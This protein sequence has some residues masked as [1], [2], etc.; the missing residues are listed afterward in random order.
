MKNLESKKILGTLGAPVF[1]T[2]RTSGKIKIV[3]CHGPYITDESFINHK[4]VYQQEDRRN[5]R[6][7]RK[8]GM[9]L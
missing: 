8:E 9:I 4:L 1:G 2:D 3:D 7:H 5:F 6:D